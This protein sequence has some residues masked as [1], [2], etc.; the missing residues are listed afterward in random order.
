MIFRHWSQQNSNCMP[1]PITPSLEPIPR[2]RGATRTMW[3]AG[4]VLLA[5]AAGGL[6]YL[7]T[8]REIEKDAQRRFDA[9]AREA[10]QR[11]ATA[12]QSYA[13]VVRGLA[14]M[15][16]AGDDVNRDEFRRYVASLDV[17]RNLPALETVLWAQYV[18]D[19]SR[20]AFVA[21]V[22]GDRSVDAAGYPGF[23]IAPPTR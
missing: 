18:P 23:A 7:L 6:M 4:G 11:L 8:A 13:G 21:R 16:H 22:R 15:Y 17:A 10:Q 3:W 14:A 1:H 20:D 12:I 2:S 19:A 5:L 9:V